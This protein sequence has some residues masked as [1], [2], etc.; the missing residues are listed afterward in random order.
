MSKA[1]DDLRGPQRGASLGIIRKVGVDMAVQKIAGAAP[2]D[3][4]TICRKAAMAQILRVVNESRRGV[5]NDQIHAFFQPDLRPQPPDHAMHLGFGILGRTAIVP[6]GALK[7]QQLE[8]AVADDSAVQVDAAHDGGIPIADV[9]VAAHIE[10]RCIEGSPQEFEILRRQVTTRYHE[11]N[12]SEKIWF[13][14]PFEL[15][16]DNI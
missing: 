5:G 6:A 3:K 13:E 15:R 4:L 9:V 2:L 16:Y 12:L 10:K 1:I 11:V 8:P 14:V 7:S